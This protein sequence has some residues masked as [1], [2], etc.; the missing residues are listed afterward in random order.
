MTVSINLISPWCIFFVLAGIAVLFGLM[1]LWCLKKNREIL[2]RLELE[3]SEFISIVGHQ[4]RTPLTIINGFLSLIVNGTYG[5]ANKKTEEA[6]KKILISADGMR[7]LVEDLL[8]ASRM[9]L[10][11]ME[12]AMEKT[13]ISNL[14]GKISED[15]SLLAKNKSLSLKLVLPKKALPLVIVD[16]VKVGEVISNLVENSIKYTTRGGITISAQARKTMVALDEK[17]FIIKNGCASEQSVVRICVSDTGIGIPQEDIPYLFKKFSRG[18]DPS[19]LNIS[20]TGLGLYIG[21]GIIEAHG[22]K[23]WVES[24]GRNRGST[25]IIELP[26]VC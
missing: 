6:L 23:I 3:N 11:K 1:R 26:G 16:T 10:G 22:G 4:L 20:G 17:G 15:F 9:E 19:R 5:K 25:C 18:K 8:N 13:N 24:R 12:F 7:K 21:K 14:L 2:Q